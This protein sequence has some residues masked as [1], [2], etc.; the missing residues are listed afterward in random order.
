MGERDTKAKEYFSDNGRFAD[1]CNVVLFG[2]E[3]VVKPEDLQGRDT[4]E[5]LSVLGVDEKEI[6]FQKWRD[7]L[8]RVVVKN[9]GDVCFMLVGIEHQSDVHYAMPVKVML[10]DALNYGAQVKEAA[11]KHEEKKGYSS[12]AEFLSGF[13]RDD[14]LT[15]VITLTVYLGAKPW[16][17]P[18]SLREMFPQ[19]DVRLDMLYPDYKLRLVI[20]Q[21]M[22]CFDQ[23]QTTLG[24][25][26]AIIKV[27][28]DK[29]AMRRLMVSNPKYKVMDNES[30]SAINT[31]LGVNI[32]LNKEGSVT[33]MCKAWEDQR[34]EDLE[35]GRR[36]GRIEGRQ[37]GRK[38]GH[39]EG[40][41]EGRMQEVFLSVQEGDYGVRRGAEKLGISE[42]E[43]ERLMVEAGFSF[44]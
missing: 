26:L 31:F 8:K 15:P 22:D 3:A 32:P 33:N 24:E 30:V 27:S 6:H 41:K 39:K 40:R 38:E 18:R 25:V 43:F 36:E 2:G 29:D 4:T 14:V 9:Y 21:E 42:E 34:K 10:Y 5:N 35:N 11:R 7:I 13:C 37:E 23:F 16:D 17:G 19:T 44:S 28:E 1:L 20:P 12:A